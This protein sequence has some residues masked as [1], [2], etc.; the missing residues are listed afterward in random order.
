MGHKSRIRR[1]KFEC[2]H[3]RLGKYCHLCRNI[4]KGLLAKNTDGKYL[5]PITAKQYKQH[6]QGENNIMT[7]EITKLTE[8]QLDIWCKKMGY[9]KTEEG[10][11]A[12]YSVDI[13]TDEENNDIIKVHPYSGS[14]LS[15]EDVE[16]I[17]ESWND[18]RKQNNMG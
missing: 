17:E 14:S 12:E 10:Y 3:T 1:N 16:R 5:P 13:L 18:K 4:E 11:V 9:K 6:K 8:K 15:R 2:G 7:T